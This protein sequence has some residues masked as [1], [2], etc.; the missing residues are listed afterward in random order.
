MFL[1]VPSGRE[2]S[3]PTYS[4]DNIQYFI[5]KIIYKLPFV[6]S[7]NLIPMSETF[8]LLSRETTLK[9]LLLFFKWKEETHPRKLSNF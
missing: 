6:L 2:E 4:C 5:S 7:S 9:N 3:D 8:K 1:Q